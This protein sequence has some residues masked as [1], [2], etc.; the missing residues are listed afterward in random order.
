MDRATAQG[1]CLDKASRMGGTGGQDSVASSMRRLRRPVVTGWLGTKMSALRNAAKALGLGK[2]L[3]LCYHAPLGLLRQS[4][5]EGGPFEQLR[6]AQGHEAMIASARSLPVL[7]LPPEG[8]R[9]SVTFLSGVR[10]WHQTAF[11]FTSLQLVCP[12]KVTPI[13]F[14]DGELNEF[15]KEQLRR[16]IPWAQ[17][18]DTNEVDERLDRVLPENFFPFLRKRRREYPH[19]RKLLDTHALTEDPILVLDSDM[20]FFQRPDALLNWFANPF[21]MYMQDVE[22]SYGYPNKLLRDLVG[23]AI[24]D[25][26]NVGLYSLDRAKLEWDRVEFWCRRQ[27]ELCGPHYF[28]EQALVAMAFAGTNALMLPRNDYIVKPDLVEGQ[29]PTAVLHHYVS[30]SKRSYF[31][32]G[33]KYIATKAESATG[34]DQN[35]S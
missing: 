19:L 29:N 9:A 7:K 25:C 16:V 27:I 24:P 28:Q 4:I 17:F 10:Y 8:P 1:N 31:Q 12:F 6:T 22:T 18:A 11:C 26:V 35:H 14:D 30:D 15:A 23:D 3:R 21:P 33:W 34:I 32:N 20:L 2:A 5:S 13:V